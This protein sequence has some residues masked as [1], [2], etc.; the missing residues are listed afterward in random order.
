M[1]DET[2]FEDLQPDTPTLSRTLDIVNAVLSDPSFCDRVREH[3]QW[4]ADTSPDRVAL[5]FL[6]MRFQWAVQG[7]AL[8]TETLKKRTDECLDR[9]AVLER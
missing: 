3:F 1:V 8:R 4:P 9:V 6:A 7:L 2:S 5:L